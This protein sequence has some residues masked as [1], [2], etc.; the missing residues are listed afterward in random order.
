MFVGLKEETLNMKK[1]INTSQ[2]YSN[3]PCYI[4]PCCIEPCSLNIQ[5]D[6]PMCSYHNEI[7]LCCPLNCLS[8]LHKQYKDDYAFCKEFH[9]PMQKWALEHDDLFLPL[10]R[11]LVPCPM[12]LGNCECDCTFICEP[13]SSRPCQS[14][15]GSPSRYHLTPHDI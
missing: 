4:D 11:P 14:K 15:Q 2:C 12:I 10:P 13:P 6:F 3:P 1:Q 7:A 8:G 9:L 5:C